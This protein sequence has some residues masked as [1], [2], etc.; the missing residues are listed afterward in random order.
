MCL[1]IAGHRGHDVTKPIF[2][3]PTGRRGLWARRSVAFALVAILLAVIAFATTLVMVAPGADLALPFPRPQARP[4]TGISRTHHP[5]K[6]WL[7]NWLTG[8]S[9]HVVQ[10]L[11]IG[12]YVP[13]DERSATS[14]R[15]HIGQLDWVVPATINVRAGTV[16]ETEDRRLGQLL[17]GTSHAPRLLPMV[18]NLGA[19]GWDGEGAARMLANPA[20]R[21]GV[22]RQ[23]VAIVTHRR[24]AGLVL[25]FES[26]PPVAMNAYLRFITQ[27]NAALPAHAKLA[28]TA[29]AGDGAWP[30]RRLAAAADYVIFMAYDQHW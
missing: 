8:K 22:I 12:F 21:A 10:P 2:F 24:A 9:Q 16:T 6:G 15:N 3:D 7:P 29:P 25:D 23:L 30:L 28:V 14:L 5:L 4:L 11:S 20:A 13:D 18:Q 17:A 19:D 26:L 27:L 1:H